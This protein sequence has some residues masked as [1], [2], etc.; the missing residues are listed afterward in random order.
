MATV[1]RDFTHFDRSFAKGD[2][3]PDDDPLVDGAP[4]LFEAPVLKKSSVKKSSVK[5]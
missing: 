1:A 5:K 3:I 4:H 2:E